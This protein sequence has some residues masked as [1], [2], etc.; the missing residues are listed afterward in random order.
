MEES[1]IIENGLYKLTPLPN[2]SDWCRHNL[3][4][5]SKKYG[6]WAFTDTYWSSY[7]DQTRYHF[8]DIKDRITFVFD[9]NFAKGVIKVEY[10]QYDDKDKFFIPVGGCAA[11]YLI[12]SRAE[13]SL[14]KIEE[15]LVER[16]IELRNQIKSLKNE[17]NQKENLLKSVQ[18]GGSIDNLWI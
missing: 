18:S 6:Y 7:Q 15:L 8:K 12:D 1:E 17:L 2:T 9:M 11:R 5:A 16:T 10:D 13:K 3:L 4:I 14:N